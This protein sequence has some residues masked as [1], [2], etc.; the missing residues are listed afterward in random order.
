MNTHRQ[1]RVWQS[2]RKL[3]NYVYK[4]TRAL[5]PEEKYVAASQM[6]RAAW[7]VHNNIAE[8]NAKFGYNERRRF[9]D[10][11]LGSLAEVDAMAVTLTDLYDVEEQL[12]ED[13]DGLRADISGG[14]FAMLRRGRR[15]GRT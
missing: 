7:S 12:I 1:L 15:N 11:A 4:L 6:R 3:V 10:V 14:L 8:G 13:I 9:F 5:P 2:A